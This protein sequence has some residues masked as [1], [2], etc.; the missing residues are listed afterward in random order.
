MRILITNDDGIEAPGIRKLAETARRFGEVWIIAPDGQRSAASHSY[1]FHHPVKVSA[2]DFPVEDVKAYACSGTPTD[3]IRVGVLGLMPEK[4][5]IVMTGINQGYNIAGD[6]QYSATVGSALEAAFLG[7]RA[8]AFSQAE[9]E[10]SEI[11]DK[12][13]PEIMEECIKIDPGKNRIMNVNFPACR[14]EECK[15]ILRNCTVSQDPF[16]EDIY[17]EEVLPEGVSEY[18]LIYKRHWEAASEG[19]DLFAVGHN[20]ISIG[21]VSNIS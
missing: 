3:C 10:Y 17:Q 12:Y 4:P 21:P 13:L 20:Y 11:V 19:T 1:N 7:I 14:P 6:I 5:D 15:G 16:Y 2:W 8:I 9:L 18:H